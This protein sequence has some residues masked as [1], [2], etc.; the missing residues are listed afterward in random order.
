MNPN[1]AAINYYKM[2]NSSLKIECPVLEYNPPLTPPPLLPQRESP[3]PDEGGCNFVHGSTHTHTHPPS[4]D[5]KVHK[6]YFF[7]IYF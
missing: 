7:L 1:Q 5:V 3:P 4:M 2:I 6:W